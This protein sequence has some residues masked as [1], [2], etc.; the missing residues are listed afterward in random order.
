M[1]IIWVN[2]A[3]SMLRWWSFSFLFF[4]FQFNFGLAHVIY[5]N[6]FHSLSSNEKAR[7]LLI[8]W[9]FFYLYSKTHTHTPSAILTWALISNDETKK[10]KSITRGVASQ[11]SLAHV[12]VMCLM[13]RIPLLPFS[14]ILSPLRWCESCSLARSLS[15]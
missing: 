7:L 13:F 2:V 11:N 15:F 14:Y 1:H 10:E 6:A 9:E 12:T 8:Q 5:P 3:W 4:L